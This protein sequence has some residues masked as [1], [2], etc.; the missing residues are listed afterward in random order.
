MHAKRPWTN[1]FVQNS[2]PWGLGGTL[3]YKYLPARVRRRGFHPG[4]KG[5]SAVRKTRKHVEPKAG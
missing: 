3:R 1:E 4:R 2:E 5:S